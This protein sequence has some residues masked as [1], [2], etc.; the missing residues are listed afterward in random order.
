MP[1]SAPKAPLSPL[2]RE[3][4]YERGDATP[5][6]G[7]VGRCSHRVVVG[8][9]VHHLPRPAPRGGRKR[10]TAAVPSRRRAQPL[11]DE[12]GLT[13]PTWLPCRHSATR[14]AAYYLVPILLSSALVRPRTFWGGWP[15]DGSSGSR[16][17]HPP[18]PAVVSPR[19]HEAPSDDVGL[20]ALF[21]GAV[22]AVI[23]ATN[24]A[25]ESGIA[26]HIAAWS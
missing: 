24:R 21:T 11:V 12:A 23:A 4:G 15:S 16:A 18:D 13:L 10:A 25:A 19:R 8:H 5:G 7:V 17:G 26:P 2:T 1:A 22:T 3:A 14:E 9:G 20:A 6:P